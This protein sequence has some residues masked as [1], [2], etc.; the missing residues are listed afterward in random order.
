MRRRAPAHNQ[1]RGMKAVSCW[2]QTCGVVWVV[3]ET[4]IFKLS[5]FCAVP[6]SQL[7]SSH[8][9]PFSQSDPPKRDRKVQKLTNAMRAFIFTNFLLVIFGIISLIDNLPIQVRHP[10]TRDNFPMFAALCGQAAIRRHMVAPVHRLH[11][12]MGLLFC[13]VIDGVFCSAHRCERIHP[14]MLRWAV[15]CCV[16]NSSSSALSKT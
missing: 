9:S 4:G 5:C 12:L 16:S 11:Q 1:P 13:L 6:V 10:W 14:F 7:A 8:V 2:S 15:R 3:T